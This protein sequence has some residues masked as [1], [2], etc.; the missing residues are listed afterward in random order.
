MSSSLS[1]RLQNVQVS[2]PTEAGG[3]QVFGL[4]WEQEAGLSY[5]TLDDGLA[6][7]L[8][9]VTEVSSGGSVPALK[10]TNKGD[11]MAFLMA[12]EQLAGGKQNRVLNASIMVGARTELPLPVSCVEARPLGVSLGAVRKHRQLVAQPLA[13]PDARP[14]HPGLPLGGQADLQARRS[15]AGSGQPVDQERLAFADRLSQQG[16]R[17]SRGRPDA[18]SWGN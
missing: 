6:S 16:L 4:C 3:L 14:R 17:G 11:T 15:L 8:L 13:P 9:E 18:R 7:G 1:E 5:V 10:V 2:E 12:G